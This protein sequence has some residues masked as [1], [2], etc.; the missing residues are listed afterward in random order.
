MVAG[1]SQWPEL[2]TR[3][4][5]G[6]FGP[7]GGPHTDRYEKLASRAAVEF[8]RPVG[9]HVDRIDREV[10]GVGLTTIPEWIRIGVQL[11]ADDQEVVTFARTGFRNSDDECAVGYPVPVHVDAYGASHR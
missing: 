11:G 7:A 2:S 1:R 5:E 4:S 8:R 9:C 10:R 3:E 6:H